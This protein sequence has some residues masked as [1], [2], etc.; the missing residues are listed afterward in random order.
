MPN[1]KLRGSP[2]SGRVPLEC[3]VGLD[4]KNPY[5]RQQPLLNIEQ[6]TNAGKIITFIIKLFFTSSDLEA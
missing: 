5:H 4:K 6:T 3:R 2:A 1:V